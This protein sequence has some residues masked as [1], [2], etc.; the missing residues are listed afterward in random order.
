MPLTHSLLDHTIRSLNSSPYVARLGLNVASASAGRAAVDLP[1]GDHN[2]NRG[3][4]LHGGAIASA[5]LA[6]GELAAASS[7]LDGGPCAGRT[8][9]L[10]VSFLSATRGDGLHATACVE[11]RGR[12][13]VH[14][15]HDLRTDAGIAVATGFTTYRVQDELPASPDDDALADA[16]ASASDDAAGIGHAGAGPTASSGAA[17]A[18]SRQRPPAPPL[19]RVPQPRSAYNLG[20]GIE[21]TDA[22][23]GW[24]SARM[25]LEPNV[26]E[27]GCVHPGAM[28]GLADTCAAMSAVST[29]DPARAVRLAT[30]AMWISFAP[31]LPGPLGAS[32][33]LVTVAGSSSTNEVE[34][35]SPADGRLAAIALISYRAVPEDDVAA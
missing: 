4:N 28:A 22:V 26:G 30:V 13:T 6:A 24:T 23:R 29:G 8:L 14:V 10:A 31:P 1:Y 11:R 3:G 7:Q 19:S 20:A 5:L 12:D 21:I 25:P 15:V 27:R 33:R 18:A 32:A 16:F 2:T 17:L 34:V 9:N 35:W